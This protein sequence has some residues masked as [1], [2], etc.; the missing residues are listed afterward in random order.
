[1]TKTEC[2]QECLEPRYYERQKPEDQRGLLAISL[3][4]HTHTTKRY[5]KENFI[6]NTKSEC[7]LPKEQIPKQCP[8][9]SDFGYSR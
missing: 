2:C 5:L 3:P 4:P 7:L 8:Q 1:M 9:D 6:L